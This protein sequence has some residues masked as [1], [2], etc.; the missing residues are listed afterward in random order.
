[1]VEAIGR[2]APALLEAGEPNLHLLLALA[3]DLAAAV[4]APSLPASL[5]ALARRP[6]K[7]R[8]TAAAAL[9][10]EAAAGPAPD[11]ARAATQSLAALVSR[12]E[13]DLGAVRAQARPR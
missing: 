4:G 12:A 3:A 8:S 7:N 5:T 9:L 13:A 2:C 10:A 6:G 11:H 1:V